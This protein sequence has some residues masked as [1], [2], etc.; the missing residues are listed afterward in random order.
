MELSALRGVAGYTSKQVCVVLR[1]DLPPAENAIAVDRIDLAEIP[2]ATRLMR[3]DQSRS[4]TTKQI[5][6]DRATSRHIFDNVGDHLHRFHS[7]MKCQIT[8]ATRPKAIRALVK[9]NIGS[10]TS[11]LS[12]LE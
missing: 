10:I 4:A 3:R 12:K 2:A 7:R 11:V 5:E 6:H 8:R 9:P 1:V